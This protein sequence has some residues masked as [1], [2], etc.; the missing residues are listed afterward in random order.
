VR[1]RAAVD[2][3]RDR[4]HVLLRDEAAVGLELAA[5]QHHDQVG[6]AEGP[7]QERARRP[8][9]GEESL[10][11]LAAVDLVDHAG[12]Q[13]LRHREVGEV[14]PVG[15]RVERGVDVH[16]RHVPEDDRGEE[17]ERAR[18]QAQQLAQGALRAAALASHLEMQQLEIVAQGRFHQQVHVGADAADRFAMRT[19]DEDDGAIHGD[20]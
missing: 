16:Q 15:A 2:A 8:P 10:R 20:S 13:Q 9:A 12:A 6:K 1:E 5:R 14:A 19:E 17:R 4:H 11:Q 18:Q 7:A 3:V